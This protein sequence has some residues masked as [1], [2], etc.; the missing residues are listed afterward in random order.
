MEPLRALHPDQT[1]S[2][3]AFPD[4]L[5]ARSGSPWRGGCPEHH[6]CFLRLTLH[7]IAMQSTSYLGV[8]AVP[9]DVTRAPDEGKFHVGDPGAELPDA[10]SIAVPFR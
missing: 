9:G 10:L 1:V 3:A 5:V 2:Q 8:P 4:A 6:P 7:Q